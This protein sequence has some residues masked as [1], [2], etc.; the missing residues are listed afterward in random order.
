MHGDLPM[1][2]GKACGQTGQ[3][4]YCNWVMWAYTHV[5]QD[6]NKCQCALF[7]IQ[8]LKGSEAKLER[9]VIYLRVWLKGATDGLV[10]YVVDSWS[11]LFKMD[12]NWDLALG[13]ELLW[14]TN[15][16]WAQC[17][18]LYAN[19]IVWYFILNFLA[20]CP[21]CSLMPATSFEALMKKARQLE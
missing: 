12:Y 8:L 4:H 16:D 9:R 19:D 20:C 10:F 3:T 7:L 13:T 2:F 5:Y 11:L 1:D 17:P 14:R 21:R 6:Q 18:N 15:N